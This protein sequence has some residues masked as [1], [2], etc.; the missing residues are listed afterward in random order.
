[1]TQDDYQKQQ[2]ER[3]SEKEDKLAQEYSMYAEEMAAL[4]DSRAAQKFRLIAH[5]HRVRAA[6]LRKAGK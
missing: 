3:D 5:K 2:M 1:M 4:G 6:E